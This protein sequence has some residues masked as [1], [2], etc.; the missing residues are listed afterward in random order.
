MKEGQR[1]DRVNYAV[2]APA[3]APV[4]K[5]HQRGYLHALDELGEGFV[6]FSDEAA[7]ATWL[8]QRQPQQSKIKSKIAMSDDYLLKLSAQRGQQVTMRTSSP[9]ALPDRK[10]WQTGKR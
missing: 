9:V 1:E 10:Y 2:D 8:V 5:H 7:L 4:Y 3:I 6:D